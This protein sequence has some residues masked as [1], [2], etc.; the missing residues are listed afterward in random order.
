MADNSK[1]RQFRIAIRDIKNKITGKQPLINEYETATVK[2]AKAADQAP[3]NS[4]LKR[5]L[6]EALDKLYDGEALKKTSYDD[7][8]TFVGGSE[9][10]PYDVKKDALKKKVEMSR[11]FLKKF[12]LQK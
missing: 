2:L 8:M 6:L 3:K 7:G 10:N 11:M 1:A 9:F 12:G 4:D 5:Q